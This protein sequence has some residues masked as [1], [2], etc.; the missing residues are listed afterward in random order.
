MKTKTRYRT[1][2]AAILLAVAATSVADPSLSISSDYIL[3]SEKIRRNFTELKFQG[4][5][6]NSGDQAATNAEGVVTSND[7]AI[8]IR[9]DK[10]RIGNIGAGI[11]Q[12]TT[13]TF[14]VR[15]PNGVQ[16]DPAVLSWTFTFK[17]AITDNPPIADAGNDATVFVGQLVML[18]G[19]GSTDPDGKPVTYSWEFLSVPDGSTAVLSDSVSVTP[20]LT[21]DLMGEYVVQLIVRDNVSF[22]EP[23]LVT[24]TTIN[25]IPVANAGPDQ[26]VLAGD[27]VQ[28]DGSGSSDAD[29]DPLAFHWALRTTPPGSLAEIN[30]VNAVMPSFVADLAGQYEAELTVSDAGST[31]DPDTVTIITAPTN[32]LPVADA[33]PDIAGVVGEEIS[34]DGS[35]SFDIDGD[36][37][38]FTWTLIS[39]P[40]GSATLINSATS[41]IANFVPDLAG[42]YVA[43][44]IVNDGQDD[45]V[46]DTALVTIEVGNTPPV[47]VVGDNIEVPAGTIVTLDGSASFDPD[48]DGLTFNWSLTTTPLDS[49]AVLDDPLI[50]TP[51]LELDKKGLYVAQLIVNDGMIAS[52]PATLTI[53]ALNRPPVAVAGGD[54]TGFV[55]DTLVFD[56]SGSFDDDNDPLTYNWSIIQRPAGSTAQILNG[57]TD[58]ATLVIDAP[59]AYEIQLVVNDSEEASL[60]DSLSVTASAQDLVTVPDAA[61]TLEDELVEISVIA[62]DS[63]PNAAELMVID[64]SGAANGDVSTDGTVATYTPTPDFFGDDSFTYTVS[65]GLATATENVTVS[66]APVND[67]PSFDEIADL[68]ASENSPTL[69]VPITGITAGP[70][71]EQQS[72]SLGAVASNPALIESIAVIYTSADASGELRITPVAQAS[73]TA[74]ITVTLIDDGGTQDGGADTF[75][76]SFNV[77]ID[78]E[79][80]PPVAVDDN[81]TTTQNQPVDILVLTNDSDPDSPILTVASVGAASNGDATTDGSLVT[82]APN[83]D[84]VGIDEFS[85]TITDGQLTAEANVT[86]T[87]TDGT[88]PQITAVVTGTLGD[89]G[90]YVSGVDVS[91]TVEDPESSVSES[92]GCDSTY[93]IDDTDGLLITCTATSDGG[94][95]SESVTIR[96]DSSA[97]AIVWSAPLT[98]DALVVGEDVIADYS[99]TDDGSGLESCSGTAD[100]GVAIDTA[101]TGSK[102]LEVVAIDLAGNTRRLS[103]DYTVNQVGDS[104]ITTIAG[105]GLQDI[106]PG[107][108]F[109]LAPE[110]VISDDNGNWYFSDRAGNRIYKGDAAGSI[111]AFA[112]TGAGGYF[113]DGGAAI[114][115]EI[116]WPR[117]LALDSIGNLYVADSGN[118]RVR[119]ISPDGIITTVAGNGTS[120]DSGDGGSALAAGFRSVSALAVDMAGAIYIVDQSASRVRK[121]SSNGEINAFAGNGTFGY[122]GD[123]G[124]AVL[125]MLAAP[126][127][128]VAGADG[129]IYIADTNN[130]RVRRVDTNGTISTFAGNGNFAAPGEGLSALLSGLQNPKGLAFDSI[131]NLYIGSLNGSVVAVVDTQGQIRRF[132]GTLQFGFGGDGGPATDARLN[133]PVDVAADLAGN[134]YV[135]DWGNFRIRRV[136]VTGLI[137]TLA[138]NGTW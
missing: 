62:N 63:S 60:P 121:V 98:R 87:V 100:N 35:L 15:V 37:L 117:D 40:A 53:T 55:G 75:V 5:V 82:Y 81:A 11:T 71:N 65:D 136:G 57:D 7:P 73:G 132:A 97:P 128:V 134:V 1:I 33:G 93:V 84:F 83:T 119:K 130:Q 31:S 127:G 137:Q 32:T 21:V 95:S 39:Q 126:T 94:S 50:I 54:Q 10:L 14:S 92:V 6:T 58:V 114:D 76:R 77:Q 49:T 8:E 41:E 110:S 106:V 23:S 113:G 16:F 133:S 118:R 29:G 4:T 135:V 104:T 52:D 138:G 109:G 101:T 120:T 107:I 123:D 38:T 48:G 80:S 19:S 59:G 44:L 18:D 69:I 112:G 47:A 115:A 56:G 27:V 103:R 74:S 90:W 12:T 61:S 42:Q 85:Y 102:E 78:E 131:G 13:D 45:S 64:V 9:D 3:V 46:P 124:P 125:A 2:F 25:S 88:P 17:K 51:S 26:N 22:S 111:V 116:Y 72:L 96:K 34:L 43:Q 108:D 66:V 20:S 129:S 30:D 91:W 79:N 36:S 105:N 122:A 28:L 67:A 68:T 86:V 24:I 70:A 99:C 89:N